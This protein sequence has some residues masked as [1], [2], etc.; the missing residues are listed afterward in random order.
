ML[1]ATQLAKGDHMDSQAKVL[2]VWI[3][4]AVGIVVT[5]SPFAGVLMAYFCRGT[6]NDPGVAGHNAAQIRSF[7]FGFAGWV[8]A[9]AFIAGGLSIMLTMET[10]MGEATI[11]GLLLAGLGFLIAIIVQ[12]TFTIYA[13]I[14]IVR[15][16]RRTNWPGARP[17]QS[18][19]AVFA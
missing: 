3:A 15:A 9:I 4:F 14:G 6:N 7:W 2:T 10:G 8:V 16:S 12:V 5:G 18:A 19:Q 17:Y 1:A 11:G 13:I